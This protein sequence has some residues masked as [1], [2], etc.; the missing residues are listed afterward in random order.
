VI[1]LDTSCPVKLYYPEPESA[2]VAALVQ[3]KPIR[4][5]SLHE[6]EFH[7]ALRLK[8]FAG[9]ATPA[10]AAAMA[11]VT[12]DLRAWRVGRIQIAFSISAFTRL[13]N[14]AGSLIFEPSAMVA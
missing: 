13:A 7:N 10:R 6:L 8:A 4:H 2:R 14:P 9:T 1:Y 11:M 5:T 12:A 3:G